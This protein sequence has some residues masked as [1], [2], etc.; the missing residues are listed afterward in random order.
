MSALPNRTGASAVTVWFHARGLDRATRGAGVAQQVEQVI[1][2]DG[3]G[4]SSP[5]SGA[6]VNP[7]SGGFLKFTQ[8]FAR[9]AL[10]TG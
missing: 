4:G 8:I 10:R 1:G 2:N 5:F 6:T 3:G 7:L 9:Q